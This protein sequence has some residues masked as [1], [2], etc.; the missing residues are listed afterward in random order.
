MEIGACPIPLAAEWK[1]LMAS[2]TD[3]LSAAQNNV[4]AINEATASVSTIVTAL[5]S[6]ASAFTS[7]VSTAFPVITLSEATINSSA[8]DNTIVAAVASQTIRIYKMFYVVS[9]AA[10]ITIKSSA[11]SLTGAI[12]YTGSASTFYDYDAHPW[13]T[14]ASNSAFI[15]TVSAAVQVSGRAYYTQS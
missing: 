3:L 14:F 7:A 5:S 1:T 15:L 8:G 2:P 11:V 6:V 13:F 12:P 9:A 10:N 4:V